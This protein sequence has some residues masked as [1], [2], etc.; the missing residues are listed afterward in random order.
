MIRN[1]I[2]LLL[3]FSTALFNDAAAQIGGGST[4]QFL[5]MPASARVSALGGASIALSDDDLNMTLQNPALA[6]PKMHNN[7]S[8]TYVPYFADI[9]CGYTSYARHFKKIGTAYA[10]MQYV[11]YGKFNLA[12]ETGVVS[13]K[14]TAS[15][16]ALHTGISH[17]IDS[18]FTIGIDL[19][20]IFSALDVY[21]SYGIAVDFGISYYS[22]KH[23]VGAALVAK[24][25]GKQLKSYNS[26]NKEPLPFEI[27]LGFFKQ[28]KHVPLRF[29]MCLTQMQ[30]FDLTWTD[31]SN[32]DP[33]VDPLTGDSIPPQKFSKFI[34]KCAR[35]LVFGA[36]FMPTKNFFV[37]LGYNYQRR[38]EL[39]LESRMAMVGFSWGFGVRISKFQISY[40]RATYHLA[41]ASNHFT[42]TT[43]LSSFNFKK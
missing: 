26:K 36:E 12:D 16:Y 24:N 21:R 37:R 19:K 4:F 30:K 2:L 14:F 33:I 13:D 41:G 15:E 5:S 3:V 38:Q 31:P 22:R 32:P 25:T 43:D 10:G 20:N 6:S 27:Q 1:R 34:D 29:S 9:T 23:L 8:L 42:V 35:H 40:G 18:L 39:K 7:L 11:N 17:R 28:L